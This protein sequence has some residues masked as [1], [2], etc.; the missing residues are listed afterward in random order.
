MEITK[1]ESLESLRR[2]DALD[3][4][5]LMLNTKSIKARLGNGSASAE[6]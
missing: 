3:I 5:L 6:G 4:S 1:K 2:H